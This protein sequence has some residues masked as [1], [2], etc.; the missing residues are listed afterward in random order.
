MLNETWIRETWLPALRSGEYKKCL[1]ALK[2]NNSYCCLGVACDLYDP[3]GWKKPDHNP[4]YELFTTGP[5]NS[6]VVQLPP[7]VAHFL[8]ISSMGRF[9]PAL[10][11]TNNHT[12]TLAHLNDELRWT[13][14]QIADFIENE[15]LNPNSIYNF[16]EVTH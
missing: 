8:G 14:T 2:V 10:E 11:G 1:E 13:F 4:G 3:L 6:S 12:T 15:L 7:S 16:S 5:G 9:E